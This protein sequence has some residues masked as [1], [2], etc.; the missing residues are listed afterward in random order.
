MSLT[1]E[2]HSL[3][4]IFSLRERVIRIVKSP[5]FNGKEYRSLTPQVAFD[6]LFNAMHLNLNALN[7]FHIRKNNGMEILAFDLNSIPFIVNSVKGKIY[8]LCI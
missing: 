7:F 5:F 2:S 6:F 4:S 1:Q 8:R 3:F